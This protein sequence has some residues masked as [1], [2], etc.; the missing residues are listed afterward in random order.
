MSTGLEKNNAKLLLTCVKV[1]D[2]A[3]G[4]YIDQNP[5]G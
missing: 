2:G 1:M 3:E 5:N 4:D